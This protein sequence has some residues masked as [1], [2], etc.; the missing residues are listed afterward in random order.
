MT[1]QEEGKF[2]QSLL[3]DCHHG[4]E[5]SRSVDRHSYTSC[6]PCDSV[7][8]PGPRTRKSENGFFGCDT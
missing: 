1:K 5:L 6:I 8:M 7:C 4:F 2:D 3:D